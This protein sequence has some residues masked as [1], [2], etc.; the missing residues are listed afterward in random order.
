MDCLV[1]LPNPLQKHHF[2]REELAFVGFLHMDAWAGDEHCSRQ[3]VVSCA[4]VSL[5]YKSFFSC[6]IYVNKLYPTVKMQQLP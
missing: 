5:A 4:V 6:R 3:S 1:I 2:F